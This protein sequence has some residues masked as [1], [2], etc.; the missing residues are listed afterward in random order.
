MEWSKVKNIIILLLLLVNGFLLVLVGMRREETE[1]Y[2]ASALAQAVEVLERSGIQVFQEGL[3]DALDMS[4]L[5]V[6][7]NLEREGALAGALLGETVE[8]KNQGGG[9]YAYR[10]NRGEVSI[11]AG[12]A[13]SGRMNGEEDWYSQDPQNHAAGLLEEMG[14]EAE[15]LESSLDGGTGT[16]S[17]RQLWQGA[18]LFSC[19]VAFTY[20][21][22][23]LTGMEGVLLM[24]DPAGAA[25]GQGNHHP[26]HRPAAFPGRDP[27]Q[28]RCV[29]PD[30]GHGAGLPGRAV[31]LRLSQPQ[32]RLAGAQQYG[33]LLPG[34]SHRRADPGGG[35]IADSGALIGLADW[36][37]AGRH[38]EIPCHPGGWPLRRI[39]K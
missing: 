6:E 11:R 35:N 5:S 19:Q 28:R 32:S 8:P 22:G 25:A 4:P 27:G 2:Q 17:F 39:P 34:R 14:V 12:G 33:A 23:S 36:M 13:I 31:L 1:N 38:G 15:V 24:A 7:R 21:E 3:E 10:G 26:A 30:P 37:S 20:E 29:L 16:V 18:P 9:L